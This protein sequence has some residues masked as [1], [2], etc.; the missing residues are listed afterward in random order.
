M[1]SVIVQSLTAGLAISVARLVILP[2]TVQIGQMTIANA[3]L[4]VK[5]D[6]YLVTVPMQRKN[7]IL[8]LPA[9]GNFFIEL[10][11]TNVSS[12]VYNGKVLLI[13]AVEFIFRASDLGCL[14]EH[15]FYLT[16]AN[17]YG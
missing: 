2:E 8:L 14:V 16:S 9:T 12:F 4:A 17:L 6:I 10:C 13:Y 3:T 5:Q 7:T 15:K 11:S 1:Y